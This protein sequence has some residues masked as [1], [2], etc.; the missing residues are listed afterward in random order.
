MRWLVS[1]FASTGCFDMISTEFE[2][3]IYEWVVDE[4]ISSSRMPSSGI[5]S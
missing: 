2:N 1:T 4:P 5:F 3:T